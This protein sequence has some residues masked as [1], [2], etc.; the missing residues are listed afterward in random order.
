MQRQA[1]QRRGGAGLAR[2]LPVRTGPQARLGSRAARG[3]R[4]PPPP[5]SSRP[6]DGSGTEPNQRR[7]QQSAHRP[8]ARLGFRPPP[9]GRAAPGTGSSPPHLRLAERTGQPPLPPA[10]LSRG[11]SHPPPRSSPLSRS[12]QQPPH[13]PTPPPCRLL[14]IPRN[15]ALGILGLAQR[16][17]GAHLRCSLSQVV[18][19]S[20]HSP[21]HLPLLELVLSHK[22]KL[23]AM[24]RRAGHHLPHLHTA[25]EGTRHKPG[26][27]QPPA[28]SWHHLAAEQPWQSNT[29]QLPACTAW[30]QP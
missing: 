5:A 2:R 10:A 20:P 30:A 6:S 14:P 12:C 29:E 24:P 23:T 16:C 25:P 19:R 8:S 13:S 22:A 17:R 28:W 4:P 3:S 21:L 9:L 26:L 11:C 18:P 7:P 15:R 27:L 1:Q